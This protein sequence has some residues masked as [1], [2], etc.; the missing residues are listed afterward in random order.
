MQAVNEL[1]GKSDGKDKLLATIQVLLPSAGRLVCIFVLLFG[2]DTSSAS[3]KLRKA[4]E[5]S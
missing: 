5:L 4:H 2:R 3:I 1:V